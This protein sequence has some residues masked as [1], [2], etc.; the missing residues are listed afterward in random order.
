MGG[1]VL[2][3]RGPPNI[4]RERARQWAPHSSP[5]P[6]TSYR[7]STPTFARIARRT[8]VQPSEALVCPRESRAALPGRPTVDLACHQGQHGLHSL[9]A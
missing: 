9:I 7:L 1:P 5:A 8:T 3:I 4:C 6:P 2:R